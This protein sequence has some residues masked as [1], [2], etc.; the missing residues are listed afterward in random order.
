MTSRLRS[1]KGF[2]LI[3]MLAAIVVINIGLLA[4]LLALNSGMVTLRRSAESSTASAIADQQVE[5][6]RALAYPAIYLDTTLLAATD[7]TYQTDSAYSVS[8]VSQTCT[9]L[10][11][12]C[13]PSQT[14]TGPDGR[15]YRVDTYIVWATPT[16]GAPVKQVTVVVRKPG[17]PTV[18]ARV[19][20]T[21]GAEF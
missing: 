8:Q 9:P 5:R 7:S 16:G 19:V 17:S 12:A 10:V 14:V 11:A 1:Q 15:S 18:L 2:A 4:I 3:E 20:S 13:T 21:A 6:F